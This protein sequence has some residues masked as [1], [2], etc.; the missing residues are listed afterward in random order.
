M[1]GNAKSG[2]ALYRASYH[3]HLHY[4]NLLLNHLINP[5]QKW[6]F[7][8]YFISSQDFPTDSWK[9]PLLFFTNREPTK[10]WG[11]LSTSTSIHNPY[12]LL[13]SVPSTNSQQS[14]SILPTQSSMTAVL[15]TR[16]RSNPDSQEH[17]QVGTFWVSIVSINVC[18]VWF[19]WPM[20]LDNSL[21][22]T[23]SIN[24]IKLVTF[25][26][27]LS[28]TLTLY[29]HLRHPYWDIHITPER[30]AI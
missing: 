10:T 25:S 16:T 24:D 9:F 21:I 30:K 11:I 29:R 14:F 1:E 7:G 28:Y 22:L 8:P 6:K 19:S 15:S 26:L 20:T 27:F 4:Y 13:L 3:H 17:Y 5:A 23:K 18:C 2:F 12:F